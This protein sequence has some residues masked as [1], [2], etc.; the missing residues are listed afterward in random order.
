MDRARRAGFTALIV[1]VMVAAA[2]GFGGPG[3]RAAAVGWP[4][5]TLVVSEVQTGGASASDEFVEV[6]NQGGGPVDLAGLE[7]VYA[8]ATGSTVT[9]K[10]TW[11]A[12]TILG[13]GKRILLANT[14][15]VYAA[16]ADV[17]YSSGFAATGG[18]IALRVVGGTPIDAVGWGDASSSFVEGTAVAAPPAGSSIE[19]APGGQAGNGTDTNDNA[20][21]WF[22]Q[23]APSPQGL[24]APAVPGPGAR[25]RRR[26]R[27][28]RLRARRPL[29]PRLPLRPRRPR[30]HRHRPPRRHR[31]RAR[32]R[33]HADIQSVADSDSESRRRRLSRP[34]LRRPPPR[35]FRCRVPSRRR[36]RLPTPAWSPSKA[37]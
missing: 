18:A 12:A 14:A 26:P 2:G 9:R 27:R 32:R 19:R 29:R 11:S 10:A 16:L 30:Q 15:G 24:A 20:A 33:P 1:V 4:P 25:R 34:R 5:S 7:V 6:A 23:G 8:T 36:E 37:C 22:V 3:V 21:D 28:R 31:P 35:R 13:P 17:T